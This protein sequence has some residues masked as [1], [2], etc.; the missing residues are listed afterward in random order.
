MAD[1]AWPER[2]QRFYS[3]GDLA[4][5]FGR[6]KAWVYRHSAPGGK[7]HTF[8]VKLG[9]QVFFRRAEIDRLAHTNTLTHGHASAIVPS[10]GTNQRGSE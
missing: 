10:V 6:P 1:T 7:L 5:M 8:S 2:E 9:K 3:A 4:A